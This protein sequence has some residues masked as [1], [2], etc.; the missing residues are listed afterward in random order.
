MCTFFCAES[1]IHIGRDDARPEA[2]FH[3]RRDCHRDHIGGSILNAAGQRLI[4]CIPTRAKR[5]RLGCVLR[6][7]LLG[8][9]VPVVPNFATRGGARQHPAGRTRI[10]VLLEVRRRRG[11]R[12][13][14]W[15]QPQ[16]AHSV[17][18]RLRAHTMNSPGSGRKHHVARSTSV[19]FP[20]YLKGD[21][22][23]LLVNQNPPSTK[24][25]DDDVLNKASLQLA[26]DFS[27]QVSQ[28]D[29]YKDKCIVVVCEIPSIKRLKKWIKTLMPIGWKFFAMP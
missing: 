14:P 29:E 19:R 23:L 13:Q 4:F 12:S 1:Y 26:V 11:P 7:R 16:R 18:F 10:L 21:P 22:F 27:H 5:S 28:T 6:D 25:K 9:V 24:M 8:A 20:K 2:C 3:C 15:Q 17:H